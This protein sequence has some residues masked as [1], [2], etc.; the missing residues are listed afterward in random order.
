MRSQ[1]K[2]WNEL[3]NVENQKTL[4]KLITIAGTQ[5]GR[6]GGMQRIVVHDVG[7]CMRYVEILLRRFLF[8]FDR[9]GLKGAASTNKLLDTCV[10]SQTNNNKCILTCIYFLCNNIQWQ[11]EPRR[12][13]IQIVYLTFTFINF[14]ILAQPS[15]SR[16]PYTSINW[17]LERLFIGAGAFFSFEQTSQP[18]QLTTKASPPF[19]SWQ[20]QGCTCH[21][22]LVLVVVWRQVAQAFFPF[23]NAGIP[24]AV[25]IWSSDTRQE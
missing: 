20:H 14:Y 4:N 10:N 15:I 16:T 6:E 3:N 24:R 2:S 11:K 13:S 8:V 9:T 19:R 22:S 18:N 25:V 21:I 1:R 23:H 17:Y 5:G 7:W 12:K